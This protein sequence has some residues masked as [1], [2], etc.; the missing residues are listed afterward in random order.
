MQPKWLTVQMVKAMH[1]QA[2][3]AFG[4]TDG[5][6]DEGVLESALG[7]PQNLY[8]YGDTPSLFALAAAYTAGIIQNHSFLDGNKRAGLLAG[9]SFLSLNGYDFRPDE[10]EMVNVIL[11]L[12]AGETDE[13]KVAIWFEDNSVRR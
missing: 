13:E 12:A 4:G 10:V 3:S 11:A 9:N 6:R 2:I 5:I 7:R 1:A 8:A